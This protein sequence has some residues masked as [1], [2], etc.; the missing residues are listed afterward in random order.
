MYKNVESRVGPPFREG[1]RFGGLSDRALP[2][3]LSRV[4][5]PDCLNIDYSERSQGCRLGF[6]RIAGPV[7]DASLRLDGVNDY[8]QFPT[9]TNYKPTTGG[10]YVGIHVVMRARPALETA[11]INRGYGTTGGGGANIFFRLTYDAATGGGSWIAYVYDAGGATLRTYTVA[12]GDY[13]HE[14]VGRYRYIEWFQATGGG[15]VTFRFWD[16]AGNITTSGTTTAVTTYLT[17]TEDWVLG[18]HMPSSGT[19]DATTP[20]FFATVAGFKVSVM[21]ESP[22]RD[23][24]ATAGN[25][26][27]LREVEPDNVSNLLSYWLLND[28]TGDN[29]LLDSG[30]L[31]NTGRIPNN[32]A[33]WD[34]TRGR[35]LNKSGLKFMGGASFV[36]LHAVDSTT[37]TN[38]FN[39]ANNKKWTVRFTYYP[40]MP[41]GA[42]SVPNQC[43]CWSGTDANIP[44]PV[45]VQIVSDKFTL[46]YNDGG[47]QTLTLNSPLVSSLMNNAYGPIRIAAYR[48]G[49]GN[50]TYVLSIAVPT[51]VLTYNT[52][53]VSAAATAASPTLV[54]QD[55]SL[56][57]HLTSFAYPYAFAGD[58]PTWG[59]I[60]D[61]QIVYTNMSVTGVFVGVGSGTQFYTAFGPGADQ[62]DW[63]GSGQAHTTMC[64][65]RMDEGSG[66][67]LKSATLP[68]AWQAFLLPLHMDGGRW[69]LGL[70]V[71]YLS[72]EIQWMGSYAR[73]LADGTKKQSLLAVAG[74]TLHEIDTVNKTMTV[75]AGGLFKGGK[76]T[77]AQYGNTLYLAS[78]NGQR[79][80]RW[81]GN[82]INPV[83]IV[84]P[85]SAPGVTIGAG[86]SIT[87][88]TY[89]LYYTFRNG[90]TGEES[91]P[92]PGT[93][94][95][96]S[97]GN[98]KIDTYTLATSPDPQ[99]TERRVYM[100]LIG[101][102]DGTTAYLAATVGDNSTTSATTDITVAPT[103][104][105][106]LDYTGHDP[107]PQ[108]S[109]VAVFKDFLFVAGNQIYPTRVWRNT[110]A[111]SLDEFYQD[112]YYA[113]VTLDSGDAVTALIPGY[114]RLYVGLQ[115]GMGDIY[116]T[117]NS[118]RPFE[119][120]IVHRDHGIVA[121][122]GWT[123]QSVN[124]FYL[125][126]FD[127][128][129]SNGYNDTNISSPDDQSSPS[130]QR[131]LR[132]LINP[133][134]RTETVCCENRSRSQVWWAITTGTNERNDA[135]LVYD[136]SLQA[137]SKYDIPA[138]FL[139]IHE[140]QNDDPS[141]FGGIG[142]YV[143]RM[144]SGTCDGT[145]SVV[146]AT[147]S[148]TTGKTISC[149]G[150]PFTGLNLA[151]LRVRLLA[152]ATTPQVVKTFTIYSNTNSNL[153]VYEAISGVTAGDSIQIGSIAAYAD[154]Q[155]DF[156]DPL[157]RK[158][159]R[160]LRMAANATGGAVN[161][162]IRAIKN[163]VGRSPSWTGAEESIQTV[164]TT[165]DYLLFRI[166]GIG[167]TWRFRVE[168]CG[169]ASTDD[170]D[171][172]DP[173]PSEAG[174]LNLL[175]MKAEAEVLDAL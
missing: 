175:E 9:K 152:K 54:S 41:L 16:E 75:V 122:L 25:Q 35:V 164:G 67:L 70:I 130:I 99:V 150:S 158:R 83:G 33:V 117:G 27:Y 23:P 151:G 172:L 26:W 53:S 30:T 138:D 87:A 15:A 19:V 12:D 143:Y 104:G 96:T 142:G 37:V 123:R 170:I 124:W 167:R 140:D 44:A 78:S 34:T 91:N 8:A 156:G 14:P 114:D 80:Y 32:A 89:Y 126:E 66:S 159:L 64:Y 45:G 79:P 120:E 77:S 90:Q 169:L 10:L 56:G 157:N 82:T 102:A 166:G 107:A 108:G 98:L 129:Q 134:R 165:D 36:H 46:R 60:D 173:W 52:F 94:F 153:V 22:A 95:T 168:E 63:N 155:W 43:L 163:P 17:T 135:V 139:C 111:G 113:D 47:L 69:D 11:L 88:G 132:T 29:T 125:S 115:D 50:G 92:S 31:A 5:S 42:T 65:L 144:D 24:R 58:G 6:E 110:V 86:G 103:S 112:V 119:A 71:P 40:D 20:Y 76:W 136:T 149:S 97:A 62:L 4:E 39:P 48:H 3:Q 93:A 131:T 38:I 162:R 81:D 101:G 116:E 154:F 2:A 28:G 160:W 68:G 85:A 147:V 73:F 49:S 105:V 57:R 51:G 174:H 145:A 7:L 13:I 121:P 137:W 127:V 55:W 161:V 84:A 128:W 1:R 146:I 148:S 106:S 133:E 109:I 74:C 118:A 18:T 100:T 59:T 72:P 171:T 141:I 21:G 61:F